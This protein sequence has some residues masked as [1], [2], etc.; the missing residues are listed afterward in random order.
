M[1]THEHLRRDLGSYVLGALD[2]ADSARLGEHLATCAECRQEL[3]SFA[4]VPGLMSR[5][6]IDEVLDHSLLPPP[7]LLPRVLGAVERERWANRNRLRRWRVAAA[8]L[9]ATA[10]AAGALFVAGQAPDQVEEQPSQQLVATAGSAATGVVA[11][12]PRDWGTSVELTV[13][14]LPPAGAYVAWIEDPAGA[15]TAVASWGPTDDGGA[16]ITG[17]TALDPQA[18]RSLT[19]ETDDGQRLLSSVG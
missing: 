11:L 2:P 12:A 6:R 1:T 17:A 14:G 15:R 16:V 13:A 18:V 8:G 5:L 10:V 19:V 9:A 4:A 7:A 3:A